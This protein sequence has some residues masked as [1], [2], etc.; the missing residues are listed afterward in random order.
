MN[1][2]FKKKHPIITVIVNFYNNKREAIRTL[3][4][5]TSKYQNVSELYYHIIAIDNNSSEPLDKDFVKSFGSNFHYIFFDN[6]LPSPCRAINYAVQITKTPF[7]VICIDGARILSPGIIKYMLLAIKEWNNPFVYTIGMHL[8]FKPQNFSIIEGYNQMVEDK[9]LD[10]INWKENGYLLFNISSKSLSSKN[11]FFSPIS[12]SN[13]FMLKRS[14]FLFSGGY[15]ELFIS[16]GGGVVNLDFFNKI[17]SSNVIQPV[18]LL[19]EASFHQFHNGIATN[20]PNEDHPWD[21]M[22]EEYF[23]IYGTRFKSLYKTPVFY[24]WLTEEYHKS[25]I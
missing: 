10:E 5:L 14:D 3:Y 18:L 25:L 22:V 20:V 1:I 15:N 16:K 8:G 23:N 13:C 6:D 24:G 12:E 17:N 2:S 9:L 4:S 21:F 7:V 11:G 19:G